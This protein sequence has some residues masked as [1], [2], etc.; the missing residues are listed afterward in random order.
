MFIN[1][2]KGL[3]FW[4]VWMNRCTIQWLFVTIW[5]YRELQK[6]GPWTNYD[7]HA[8]RGQITIE[9]AMIRVHT[10]GHWRHRSPPSIKTT[11]TGCHIMNRDVSSAW[12]HN[13]PSTSSSR[14]FIIA[15]LYSEHFNLFLRVWVV[16]DIYWCLCTFGPGCEYNALFR[17]TCEIFST[18]SRHILC[19]EF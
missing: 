19:R 5:I 8:H 11:L 13:F 15:N 17:Y 4:F 10:T 7:V 1:K 6:H 9:T 2:G 16:V 18:I 3:V 14:R 12:L